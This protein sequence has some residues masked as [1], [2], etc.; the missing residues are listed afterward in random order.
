MAIELLGELGALANSLEK[1]KD[2]FR[3][4]L[5]ITYTLN[6]RFFERLVLP[7]LHRLGC[8]YVGIICD[9]EAYR[10]SIEDPLRANECGTS[11]VLGASIQ[12][13][14]IQHGKL[15][16]LHGDRDVLLVGSHN[17][18][19]SG[20]NDQLEATVVLDSNEKGHGGAISQAH[21]AVS[22][23]VAQ[24]PEVSDL[25]KRVAHR[26]A[27]SNDTVSLLW[28]GD[29][30]LVSQMLDAFGPAS[31]V[32]L[33]VP[34]LDSTAL[35]ALTSQFGATDVSLTIPHQGLDTSL[36]EA[37]ATV[38]GLKAYS[39]RDERYLHAKVF[40]F[41]SQTERWLAIGSANCTEAGLMRSY[42]SGGNS[43]FLVCVRGAAFPFD[44]VQRH[45]VADPGDF[46]GTGRRDD[47]APATETK[48][49]LLT[50]TFRAGVLTLGWEP[51]VRID[52]GCLSF[53]KGTRAVSGLPGISLEWSDTPPRIVKL[54]GASGGQPIS[55]ASWVLFPDRIEESASEVA[56]RRFR[57]F[58]ASE[59]PRDQARGIEEVLASLLR[60][61]DDVVDVVEV[62]PEFRLPTQTTAETEFV[63]SAVEE[64]KFSPDRDKIT[65]LAAS[66][67]F[68]ERAIDP[69]GALRGLVETLN[70]PPPL[71]TEQDDGPATD[72][73]WTSRREPHRVVALR[74]IG[75]RVFRHLKALSDGRFDWTATDSDRV[76]ACLKGTFEATALLLK[77]GLVKGVYSSK[78][79]EALIG[80]LRFADRERSVGHTC[81]QLVVAGPLLVTTAAVL[82]EA[83]DEHDR[84]FLR[85]W[86]GRLSQFPEQTVSRW[87]TANP[88]VAVL[89]TG[90]ARG[91]QQEA[92]F[93]QWIRPLEALMDRPS[94]T[95]VKRQQ[96]RWGWLLRLGESRS[97]E[98]RRQ[99]LSEARDQHGGDRI[100]KAAQ[101][102][103]EAGRKPTIVRLT[104][105]ACR[106]CH[107]ILSMNALRN[108]KKGDAELC[109]C[110]A[111]LL[112]GHTNPSGKSP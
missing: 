58:F 61:V 51:P 45:P 87:R 27:P 17:L 26:P 85:L 109:R 88:A 4:A 41:E 8:R 52:S 105:D 103:V 82:H 63:E 80:F 39:V 28:S 86:V 14:G 50:S 94:M 89:I 38:P 95:A 75:Q 107:L 55:G 90:K 21:R 24:T 57:S 53:E 71:W 18:T 2:R 19:R 79:L 77:A 25:W 92:L 97:V 84:S 33:A 49:F 32:K 47:H 3:V 9:P 69:L 11:Y 30:P 65:A 68:R 6:L 37:M 15:L 31:R 42:G 78:L 81:Q 10:M 66:L 96:D 108:L 104:A 34:F 64:F 1:G 54:I 5:L 13:G 102:H 12:T 16:W 111:I 40:E 99:I 36:E 91:P 44:E 106:R 48:A 20:M 60:I 98:A 112:W 70:A 93:S 74:R 76:V 23:L 29:G 56:S 46:P 22:R 83:K 110:G 59:D 7:L 67:A 73:E 100:W 43:E 72:A 62:D 101:R 35:R